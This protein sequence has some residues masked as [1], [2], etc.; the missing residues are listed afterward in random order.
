M[1]TLAR[2]KHF[3]FSIRSA[4]NEQKK[5]HNLDTRGLYYKSFVV[6][7]YNC[8]D[9]GQYYKTMIT[10]KAEAVL[11]N[12]DRKLRSYLWPVL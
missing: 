3:N 4:R 1:K 12:Y 6:V 8:N 10:V 11:I 5:F 9:S 2:A 7:I